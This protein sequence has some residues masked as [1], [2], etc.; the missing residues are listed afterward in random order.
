MMAEVGELTCEAAPLWA[1]I[2]AT[3]GEWK[4]TILHER[5]RVPHRK[6]LQ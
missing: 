3:G 2:L 5:F 6:E 1:A 4:M